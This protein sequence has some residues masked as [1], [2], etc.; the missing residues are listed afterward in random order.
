MQPDAVT[1]GARMSSTRQHRIMRM[2]RVS[3]VVLPSRFG[4]IG[5][6]FALSAL[7]AGCGGA[8]ARRDRYY[9]K[10]QTLAAA[11]DWEKAKVELRNA[12]QIDPTDNRA[13]VLLGQVSEKLGDP[14]AAAQMYQAALE[15]DKN[16]AAAR[17]GLAKLYALGGLPDKAI[18]LAE[19]GLATT[20]N[21]AALLTARGAARARLGD[22]A[23]ALADAQ[24]AYGINGQ[25]AATIG[26]LASLYAGNQQ[27]DEAIKL[28]QTGIKY[29]PKE[30]DF[31]LILA[32]LYESSGNRAAAEQA[33]ADLVALD[34]ANLARRSLQV[35]FLLRG[36]EIDKAEQSLRAAIQVSPKDIKPKLALAN[37]LAA[38]RDFA[39]GEKELLALAAS[40]PKDLELQIGLA[41]FY[42][43]HGKAAQATEVYR[44]VIDKDGTGPQGLIARNRLAASALQA[45]D[46][47]TAAKL[48][49][50]VLAENPQDN[51]ALGLRAEIALSR[52]DAP[53]AITDLRALLRDKPESVPVQRALARAYL[54]N[55]DTALA[56]QTLK[57]ALERAPADAKLQVDAAQMLLESGK[58]AQALQALEQAV[59][60]DPANLGAQELL[61]RVQASRN[62]LAGARKTAQVVK[63]ARPE[64]ALGDYLTGLVDRMENK[65]DAARQSFEQALK[66]QP[67]AAEPLTGLVELLVAGGQIDP[68]LKRLDQAIELR[69]N[70]AAAI[71]LKGEVLTAQKRL[72]EATAAFRQSVRVAPSWWVP[73]RGQAVA[74]LMAKDTAAAVA[75]Y[76]QGIAAT[77]SSALVVD[78]ASLYEGMK[79]PDDAIAVYEA[80]L[81][82]NPGS[83]IG[84]NN[85]A[86]TLVAHRS[87]TASLSR[88]RELSKPLESSTIPSYLNTAGWVLYKQGDYTN[89]IPLLQK[90]SDRSPEV[91]EM[92][93][94]LGMA[95]LKA[96]QKQQARVNLEAAVAAGRPFPGIDEAKAALAQSQQP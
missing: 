13:R 29:H 88:A 69:P 63:S 76:Q 46:L 74:S 81:K 96:G 78:L 2:G 23:G 45:K 16:D 37:L 77:N 56:E 25:D 60:T 91:S 36:N 75:A 67:D 71:N 22:R 10:A 20:P 47:D 31:R 9:Q 54:L 65:P 51:D 57:A 42:A 43:L 35:Q 48:L 24:K 93:Y 64:L 50:E 44:K 19:A 70:N 72:P 40:S 15:A 62:D 89:A 82:R 34:P 59:A 94:M 4:I 14:R 90:A 30:P 12:L 52:G 11:Q 61:F 7:L 85:L 18:E 27:V 66:L 38:K 39:T 32:G 8:E 80:F 26:L 5:A 17:A 55:K 58:T 41:E 92:K 21:D 83:E 28:I 3:S 87:D 6:V 73:Y 49:N 1:A 68:A 33:F 95:Q 86:M 79:R 84:A 53:S